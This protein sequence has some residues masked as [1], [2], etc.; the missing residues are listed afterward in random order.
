MGT[1]QGEER[2]LHP[3]LRAVLWSALLLP[4]GLLFILLGLL[5]WSEDRNDREKPAV[6]VEAVVT[7]TEWVANP[8]GMSYPRL[9][10]ATEDGEIGSVDDRPAEVGEK[11]TV[12]RLG[13]G[14]Y[15]WSVPDP[16]G[17]SIWPLVG[18]GAGGMCLF[19]I[20]IVISEARGELKE[21]RELA[22]Q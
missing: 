5:G 20:V 18:I 13:S 6:Q 11:I 10:I 7:A 3:V 21:R 9:T 17:R 16:D 4:V 8:N 12:Y 19:W 15:G 1:D 22:E 2:S 14:L